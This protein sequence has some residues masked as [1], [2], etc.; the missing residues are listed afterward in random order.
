V[1]KP[2]ALDAASFWSW[3]SKEWDHLQD[4]YGVLFSNLLLTL[5]GIKWLG[6]GLGLLYHEE[7]WCIDDQVDIVEIACKLPSSGGYVTS[8]WEVFCCPSVLHIMSST[9]W[10]DRYR[11]VLHIVL[12]LWVVWMTL[13]A[14]NPASI[15]GPVSLGHGIKCNGI[16]D[17]LVSSSFGV[18]FFLVWW[19]DTRSD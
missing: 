2:D 11:F 14:F 6:S 13:L 19:V 3:C 9:P 8:P 17:W 1:I 10:F 15:D 16:A 5:Y 7:H 12:L 18:F 4:T